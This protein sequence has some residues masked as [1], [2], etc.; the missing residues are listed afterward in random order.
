MDESILILSLLIACVGLLTILLRPMFALLLI[1]MINPFDQLINSLIDMPGGFTVGR[2]LGILVFIGWILKFFLSRKS[3][4]A[5]LKG[6]NLVPLLMIFSML[7]STLLSSYP[8]LSFDA[9]LKISLLIIMTIF[10]Q[11]FV[12]SK[13]QL[14]ILIS[15]IALS[16]GIASLVGIIQF[17]GYKGYI[18]LIGTVSNFAGE[19]VRFAGFDSNPNGYGMT[20]MSGMPFL[21]FMMNDSRTRTL[22][23]IYAFFLLTSV[24]S[25]YLTMSRT[26]FFGLIAFVVFIV[27]S[28]LK[29]KQIT[30]KQVFFIAVGILLSI[31]ILLKMPAFVSDRLIR[32]TFSGRDTSVEARGDIFLKGF[33]ILESNPLFGAGFYSSSE[34]DSV[35]FA[36]IKGYHGH[37]MISVYFAGTGMVGGTL[38]VLLCFMTYRYLNA[39]LKYYTSVSDHYLSNF[40]STVKY[41][42]GALLVTSLANPIV[43]QRIFWV[44]VALAAVLSRWAVVE[45][46]AVRKKKAV[47]RE[48]LRGGIPIP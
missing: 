36:N 32:D 11:D 15:V 19:G 39:A 33:E 43:L 38:F 29:D 8:T 41:A 14:N 17:F 24:V 20:L 22:K 45:R 31:V 4:V 23:F 42:F 46:T 13:Q 44:Y 9:S 37:D 40:T 30:P 35:R 3:N 27:L 1:L 34:I 48:G 21:Y 12:N 5:S 18:E 10:I 7:V 28:K 25:L 6:F 2:L 47:L 16:A 26:H